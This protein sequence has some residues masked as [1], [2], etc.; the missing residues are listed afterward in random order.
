MALGSIQPLTEMSTRN[1]SWGKCGRCVGPT[2]LP[3]SCADFL[4]IW[5]SQGLSRPV[6][7]LLFKLYY[8][9]GLFHNDLHDC[10]YL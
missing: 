5:D 4:K 10:N 3:P 8:Y 6:M 2:T 9:T 7:G 1:I